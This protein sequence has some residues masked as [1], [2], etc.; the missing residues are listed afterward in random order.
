VSS[1]A[2]FIA[3]FGT[4]RHC[5]EYP[6]RVLLFCA[7]YS[8]STWQA[9]VDGLGGIPTW[10]D[11]NLDKCE[12][13]LYEKSVVEK[14]VI[15]TSGFQLVPPT[16]YFGKNLP[17]FAA[18]LR[19]VKALMECGLPDRLR[20]CRFAVDASHILQTAPTLGGFLSLNI[21]YH[22]NDAPHTK[23]YMRNFATCGPGSR[24]FL[25]RMFGKSAINDVAMEQAGLKWLYDNQ[26]R[27]WARL[28]EDPP[29]AWTVGIRPG[30]RVLDFENAL[31]WAHRYVSAYQRKGYS[32][33]ADLPPPTYDPAL[34][35]S[36]HMPHWCDEERYTRHT[37]RATF[38]GD[39]DE[40]SQKLQE[41]EEGEGVY[42]VEKVVCRKGNRTDKDGLFRVRWKGY[43]P[44][45][46]SWERA[47]SLV[48][49]AEEAMKEW[50][51]WEEAMW[52]TIAR[53]TAEHPYTRPFPG[54]KV[55]E[56]VDVKSDTEMYVTEGARRQREERAT[57]R[58]LR[59]GRRRVKSEVKGE[60]A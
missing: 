10:K 54:V 19:L 39:Y 47:S 55:E 16:I 45:E 52:S 59:G 32:S 48:D 9:L 20:Q 58:A 13:I 2:A 4:L 17:H 35:E 28:G 38:I 5:T 26:W 23:F 34:T 44:E 31:C 46:D 22:L 21:L 40:E 53:I 18:S 14:Q 51:D 8:E 24:A 3:R 36:T 12:S 37:S 42:E 29:H 15:Y 41:E 43:P 11:F 30:M 33:L 57:A 6:V 49:G 56:G 1:G 27:Y 50:I 7:F 25:Q 60:R